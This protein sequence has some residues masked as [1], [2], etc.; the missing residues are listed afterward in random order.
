M[1]FVRNLLA[2]QRKRLVGT[3]M[4]HI[5]VNVYPHLPEPERRELRKKVL[6]ATSTYHDICLD[7]VKASVSDG[8]VVNDEALAMLARIN[9]EVHALRREG[10]S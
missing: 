2:E 8:S 5:E 7:M 10:K 1:Q 6:A 9:A 3:L 4:Q